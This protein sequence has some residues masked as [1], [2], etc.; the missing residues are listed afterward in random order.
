MSPT[1]NYY[2]AQL[3]DGLIFQDFV[4]EVLNR[5]GISTVAYGSRL[6]QQKLGENKG[7]F[8][9]KHDKE[10]ARTG[11]L[12]IEVAEKSDPEN[13]NYVS[14]GI[15]RD[16]VEYVIGNYDVF[17]RLSTKLLRA[18]RDRSEYREVENKRKTSLGF[19]LKGEVAER[20]AIQTIRPNMASLVEPLIDD[21]KRLDGI[22]KSEMQ[23]IISAMKVD[24]NQMDLFKEK[25]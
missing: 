10:Y 21:M 22:A 8:E 19:L 25:L 16:C 11:N 6:F 17:Y 9:I 23:K 12:W 7:G 24:P 4:Y 1:D 2:K 15:C 18:F 20:V 14:S 5:H 13:P 3:E